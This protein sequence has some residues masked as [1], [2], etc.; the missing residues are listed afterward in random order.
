MRIPYATG[1]GLLLVALCVADAY[2]QAG[3]Q[4]GAFLRRSYG[5]GA[6][7]MGSAYSAL[8]W[9][10]SAVYWN[11][12]GL[13]VGADDQLLISHSV[14]TFGRRQT[15]AALSSHFTDRFAV[16]VGILNFGVS[17][18]EGRDASGAVT[19]NFGSEAF[20]GLLALGGRVGPVAVGLTGKLLYH[21]LPGT[22]AFGYGSDVGIMLHIAPV[23]LGVVAQDLFTHLAWDTDG[24]V[25]ETIPRTLR[26][27]VGLRTDVLPIALAVETVMVA[28]TEQI[29]IRAGAEVRPVRFFGLR[30]GYAA[31][32]PTFGAFV[33]LPA[34]VQIDYAATRDALGDALSHHLAL[35]ID[36]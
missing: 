35:L 34:V 20:G 21:T 28:R 36:L 17:G 26:A 18:I 13:A 16:G 2:A 14:L 15:F 4:A 33:R 23:T 22:S 24:E 12:A 5:P 10:A 8:A 25:A 29:R 30:G 19:E 27:G 6:L 1:L 11:P 7:A 3:G 9:D 32:E 31:G